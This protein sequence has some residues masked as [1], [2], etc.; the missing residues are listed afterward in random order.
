MAG[1]PKKILRIKLNDDPETDEDIGYVTSFINIL[2]QGNCVAIL[3]QLGLSHFRTRK[4]GMLIYLMGGMLSSIFFYQLFFVDFGYI[5][6]RICA[7]LIPL[8]SIASAFYGLGLHL[9]K[10]WNNTS[11]YVLFCSCFAGEFVA[12]CL[13]SSTVDSYITRP[14]LYFLVLFAVSI[15]SIF[16]PLE[17]GESVYVIIFISFVRHIS[18][19]S[20]IDLPQ[21]VR[22]FLAY[23]SGVCGV[24]VAKYMEASLLIPYENGL[25]S[26]TM[27]LRSPE[28]ADKVPFIKKRRASAIPAQSF[29][30][31]A[32]RRTSLPALIQKQVCAMFSCPSLC[33]NF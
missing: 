17:T 27:R 23:A 4:H 29:A 33:N 19:T 1:K 2:Q 16:S 24:I 11:I 31:R 28:Q 32:G 15:A 6:Q 13:C 5:F 25:V 21:F 18:C 10:S 8:F 14:S 26:S 20:L 7:I 9:R 12:Q 22:P 30:A 3:K